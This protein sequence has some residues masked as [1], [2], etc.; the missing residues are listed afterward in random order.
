MG[1]KPKDR[2]ASNFIIFFS[3]NWYKISAISQ[4]FSFMKFYFTAYDSKPVE[5]HE[6]VSNKPYLILFEINKI[7]GYIIG[8]RTVERNVN[9]H[10]K[11][12]IGT[13]HYFHDSRLGL[14]ADNSLD[15]EVKGWVNVVLAFWKENRFA[16]KS[17]AL[18]IEVDYCDRRS[19]D[20]D[21]FPF[22]AILTWSLW[23]SERE[24]C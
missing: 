2:F 15:G 6:I 3:S 17:R 8:G 1:T 20:R 16:D 12:Y 23:N 10:G 24:Y 14:S 4:Y 5:I 18:L 7:H 9:F 11:K 19:R 21:S 22:D 13:V